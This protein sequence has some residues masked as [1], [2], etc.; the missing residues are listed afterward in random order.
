MERRK[1]YKSRKK[2][3]RKFVKKQKVNT[4]CLSTKIGN[5][6]LSSGSEDNTIKMWDLKNK[7]EIG[8]LEKHDDFVT[9]LCL[10]L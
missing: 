6:D 10:P 8:I 4:F 3:K 2:K 7:K 9:S 1:E 5:V